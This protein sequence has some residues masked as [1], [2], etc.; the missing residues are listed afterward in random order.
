[1]ISL[2]AV[3][4]VLLG[5]VPRGRHDRVDDAWVDR[6]PVGGDLDRRPA[7]R[8]GAGEER[9]R[10]TG[11][12]ALREEDVDDLPLLIDRA[13]EVGPA[14]RDLDVRFIDEPPITGRVPSMAGRR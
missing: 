9:P 5:D 12:A 13:V 2:H 11:I 3:V 6:R 4:A 7:V 14:P 8:E 10:S 1:M